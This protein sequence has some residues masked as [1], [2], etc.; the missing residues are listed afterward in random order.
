MSAEMTALLAR[1]WGWLQGETAWQPCGDG[2]EITTPHLDRHNDYTQLYIRP[3]GDGFRLSDAGYILADLELSGFRW[4]PPRREIL[5]Q[6]LRGFGVERVDNRL[7]TTA[8]WDDFP[9]ELHSLLQ[10][11]LAVNDLFFLAQASPDRLPAAKG[12]FRADAPPAAA[13]PRPFRQEVAGWLDSCGILYKP[14][15]PLP[16]KSGSR[17]SFPFKIPASA[18]QPERLLRP[19]SPSANSMAWA[20]FSGID[21]RATRPPH[22]RLYALV[23]DHNGYQAN[24]R[25]DSDGIR[26]LRENYDAVVPW[27]ERESVQAELAA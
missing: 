15:A 2:Y 27:S 24:Y 26:E 17:H 18:T 11:M 7:E 14:A 16:G 20:V 12:E 22:S 3:E 9:V 5:A 23:A 4:D 8:G 19:V 6:I 25:N 1:Y 21:T 10:A 13:L